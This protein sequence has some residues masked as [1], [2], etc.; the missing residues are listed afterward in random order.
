MRR[1]R[2]ISHGRGLCWYNPEVWTHDCTWTDSERFRIASFHLHPDFR[3]FFISFGLRSE[4]QPES[5][6]S[7]G[8][9]RLSGHVMSLY[10]STTSTCRNTNKHAASICFKRAMRATRRKPF[11]AEKTN[12][13]GR[14]CVCVF[15]FF[16]ALVSSPNRITEHSAH[17][18]YAHKPISARKNWG[19]KGVNSRVDLYCK[20]MGHF[21]K[22]TRQEAPGRPPSP[23]RRRGRPSRL[24]L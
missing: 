9:A 18:L 21:Q 6:G 12:S 20:W 10:G 23:E 2:Y 19:V 16:N 14:V 4:L 24:A 3:L 13:F 1:G 22:N 11:S 5:K 7:G 8:H 15:I 17:D